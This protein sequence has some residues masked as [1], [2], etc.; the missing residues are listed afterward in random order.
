MAVIRRAIEQLDPTERLYAQVDFGLDHA[1]AY[2]ILTERQE[3]LAGTLGCTS[4]T[5]RRHANRALS[6]L[7]L[8]L[9]SVGPHPTAPS[10]IPNV[11]IGDGVASSLTDSHQGAWQAEIRRFWGLD[12]RP[13]VDIVC[14]EISE[15]SRPDFASPKDRNYLRYAKFAD[16]DTRLR[17]LVQHSI[18]GDAVRGGQRDWSHS[19]GIVEASDGLLGSIG[20]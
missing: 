18:T 1:H 16:L 11:G 5:V 13:T 20:S 9:L 15:E 2:P 10:P 14:S 17:G 8:L 12:G 3:S 7:A 6:T 4:K 19:R